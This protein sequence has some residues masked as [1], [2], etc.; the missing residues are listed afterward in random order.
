[1][2]FFCYYNLC[3]NFGLYFLRPP[4]LSKLSKPFLR[5]TVGVLRLRFSPSQ[6]CLQSS[7]YRVIQKASVLVRQQLV[8]VGSDSKAPVH[9]HTLGDSRDLY[10]T[11]NFE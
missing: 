6:A 4:L 7:L 3:W 9:S 5:Q 8:E 11:V 1:M 10:V 2:Q